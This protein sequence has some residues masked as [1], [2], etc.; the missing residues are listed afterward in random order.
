MGKLEE[1]LVHKKDEADK[2]LHPQK[3]RLLEDEVT[4]EGHMS[5]ADVAMVVHQKHLKDKALHI[6]QKWRTAAHAVTVSHRRPS[7]VAPGATAMGGFAL[8]ALICSAVLGRVVCRRR[9]QRVVEHE[10]LVD[11]E[12]N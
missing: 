1:E 5:F 2:A 6:Q 11:V 12:M 4:S 9:A 10:R 7:I 3:L 8:L